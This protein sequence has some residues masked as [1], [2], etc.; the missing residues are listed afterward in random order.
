MNNVIRQVFYFMLL[1]SPLIVVSLAT[2]TVVLLILGNWI[3]AIV[4]L[5][6]TTIVNWHTK[7]FAINVSGKQTSRNYRGQLKILTYNV[8]R[9]YA[10]SENSCNDSDLV[11]TILAQEPDIILLQEFNPDL[12]KQVN[13]VLTKQYQYGSKNDAGSRFKSVYSKYLIENYQQLNEGDDVL[14]ICLMRLNIN[15]CLC[16]IVN[17][18][19]MSNNV[20]VV[21]RAVRRKGVNAIRWSKKVIKNIC[22]GYEIRQKQSEVLINYIREIQEPVL[23]CG[24]FNDICCSS[25]LRKFE[26]VGLVDAWWNNGFGFGFSFSGQKM[27]FRLDHILYSTNNLQLKRIHVISSKVSDHRPL[28]ACFDIL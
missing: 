12:H 6:C 18:H 19:L 10:D 17:C 15:G 7:V 9:A 28:V 20:S 16:W 26:R 5:C 23:V 2:A 4:L 27:K 1:L 8:N 24:D 11:N 13:E 14:P 21:N 3:T 25:T 22:H